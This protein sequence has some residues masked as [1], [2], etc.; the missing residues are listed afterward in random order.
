[1]FPGIK[2]CPLV[3]NMIEYTV[4]VVAVCAYIFTI[5]IQYTIVWLY[6]TIVD[7]KRRMVRSKINNNFNV[8]TM[9]SINQLLKVIHAAKVLIRDKEVPSPVSMIRSTAI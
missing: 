9:S 1:M 2:F 6:L 3:R 8:I 4:R 5:P 7:S